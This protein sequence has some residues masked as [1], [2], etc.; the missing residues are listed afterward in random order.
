MPE[1]PFDLA[2]AHRWFAV[3]CNNAAWD[4]VESP[5]RQAEDVAQMIHAAHAAWF[6]WKQV[7]TA[8]NELRAECLLATA[9]IAAD[10]PA[11]ASRHADRCQALSDQ[12]GDEQSTF[13][14][15]TAWG[16]VAAAHRLSG[17]MDRANHAREKARSYVEELK[18]SQDQ[19]VFEKLYPAF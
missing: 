3:E 2:R 10:D 14:R 17:D 6:H 19:A 15:A 7:G 13:D 9:Y 4:L 8:V 1:P 16:C 5:T 11:A 12:L 18:D